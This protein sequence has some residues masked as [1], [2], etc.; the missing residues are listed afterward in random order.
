MI[1]TAIINLF[2]LLFKG[3]ISLLPTLSF[4]IPTNICSTIANFFSGVTYFFP[5]RALLP[6]LAFSISLT[7][8]KIVYNLILRIKSFIPT[9]GD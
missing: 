1:F 6:I 8:F 2:L 7:A 9:M 4:T 3:L 5:I